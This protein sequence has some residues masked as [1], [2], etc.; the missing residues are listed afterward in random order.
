MNRHGAIDITWAGGDHTFRLGLDEIQ[1]L[2]AACNMSVFLLLEAAGSSIPL[3][4]NKQCCDTIRLGLIGGGTVPVNARVLTRR[5]VEE[6]PLPES[7]GLSEAILRAAIERVHGQE[8]DEPGETE[9]AKSDDSTSPPSSP[10]P[11]SSASPTSD[12]SASDNTA[13]S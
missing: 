5:W 9:A 11:P 13:P 2:E 10:T 12:A 8:T 4:T 3:I 7:V 1:E 6:R